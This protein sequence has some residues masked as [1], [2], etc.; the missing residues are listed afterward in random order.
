MRW[1]TTN[2]T[3]VLAAREAPTDASRLALETLCQAYW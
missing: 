2:W 1:A 3:Q